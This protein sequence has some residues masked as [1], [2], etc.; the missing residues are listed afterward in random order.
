MEQCLEDKQEVTLIIS[1]KEDEYNQ[2][3]DKMHSEIENLQR[4]IQEKQ[5]NENGN[6]GLLQFKL[7]NLW[8]HT[9][10]LKIYFG[11]FLNLKNLEKELAKL[12][13][14]QEMFEQNLKEIKEVYGQWYEQFQMGNEDKMTKMIK[15]GDLV[16]EIEEYEEI[17]Q[18]ITNYK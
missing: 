1:Q 3:L 5:E 6:F 12:K 13:E 18:N 14:S 17:I 15:R 9:S 7:Q 10:N 2:Q 4:I 16:A 11:K 8:F